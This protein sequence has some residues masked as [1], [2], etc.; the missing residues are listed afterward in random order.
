VLFP[1]LS[2]VPY[3]R[4]LSWERR[5]WI[6]LLVPCSAVVGA[7]REVRGGERKGLAREGSDWK[8]VTLHGEDHDDARLTSCRTLAVSPLLALQMILARRCCIALQ[9]EAFCCVDHS[10]NHSRCQPPSE[11]LVCRLRPPP[12]SRAPAVRSPVV[13]AA[14]VRWQRHPLSKCQRTLA[15][16]SSPKES[17]SR[18]EHLP[19]AIDFFLFLSETMHHPTRTNNR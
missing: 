1:L 19:S 6:R 4:Q 16:P 18:C 13:R 8:R 11:P 12:S 10:L 9:I 5:S 3:S 17:G 14:F 7:S 15:T 2:S